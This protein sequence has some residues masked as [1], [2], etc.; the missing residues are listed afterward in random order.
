M[1]RIVPF[2]FALVACSP[3]AGSPSAPIPTSTA[4]SAP[5]AATPTPGA[6]GNDDAAVAKA[7]QEFLDL[8][9]EIS[10]EQAT[11]LGLHASDALLDDR[12]IAGQDKNVDREEAMAKA[13]RERF[14]NPKLSASGKT[15]LAMLIGALETD[16]RRKR[17]E[18][19]LQRQPGVYTEPLEAIFQMTAR[20][21]APAAERARNVCARL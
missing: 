10:P 17:V 15:D 12:T 13:L 21:Y 14:K 3:A 1:R 9:V 7:G 5:T 4:P 6:E 19:P 8:F 2:L 11:A 20:D 18:R 16:V